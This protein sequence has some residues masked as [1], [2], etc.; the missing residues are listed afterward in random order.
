MSKRSW[1]IARASVFLFIMGFVRRMTI[2]VR[3]LLV[4]DD[5]VLLVRHSYLPGW[6]LPGGGVDPGETIEEG[7][8]REVYEETGFK[9]TG[10]PQFFGHYRNIIPPGRDHV[11][12]FICRE[13]VEADAFEPNKE[14]V[15]IGWYRFNALP[16]DI[17]EATRQR[18]AEV[19]EGAARMPNWVEW[20][21]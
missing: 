10:A 18:I 5:Q 8:V 3:A 9:V 7:M 16:E 6:H 13:F 14:I 1:L 11:A 19:F 12:L 15:E 17:S 2:G 20:T 4:K 21:E